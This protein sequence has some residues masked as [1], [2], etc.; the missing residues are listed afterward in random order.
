MKCLLRVYS[1][2]PHFAAVV[3][4]SSR[5]HK[6]VCKVNVHTTTFPVM[7]EISGHGG[8]KFFQSY[9]KFS[10]GL[11]ETFRSCKKV[12]DYSFFSNFLS[13]L[14]GWLAGCLCPALPLLYLGALH[15]PPEQHSPRRRVRM[16]SD[17]HQRC[18]L[19]YLRVLLLAVRSLALA[20][21]LR[22]EG[23]E[24]EA[25]AE[26]REDMK[27]TG[28]LSMCGRFLREIVCGGGIQTDALLT[29]GGEVDCKVEVKRRGINFPESSIFQ[30]RITL[31]AGR[32]L[33]SDRFLR[34]VVGE[35]RRSCHCRGRGT[36][37]MQRRTSQT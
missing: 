32:L 37:G 6:E 7:W 26:P 29:G 2:S 24:S 35:S 34:K 17:Q 1:F 23:G 25:A 16:A 36:C 11:R 30:P 18:H 9:Q 19:A 15:D 8:M 3:D 31:S 14:I 12:C 10:V 28:E 13:L 27:S 5:A 4:G 21:F 33:F 22:G 20:A